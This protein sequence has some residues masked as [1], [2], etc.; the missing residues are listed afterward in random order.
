MQ[1]DYLLSHI[2]SFLLNVL[3]PLC[4]TC[5]NGLAVTSPVQL[6]HGDR[7]LWGNNHFFRS[8]TF[9]YVFVWCFVSQ[10]DKLGDLYLHVVGHLPFFLVRVTSSFS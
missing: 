2:G 8:V 1:Y 10:T 6:H 4:R 9:D 3:S 5:V 7:I